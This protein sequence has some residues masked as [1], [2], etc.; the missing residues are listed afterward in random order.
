MNEKS[1][2]ITQSEQVRTVSGYG[3]GTG[4]LEHAMHSTLTAEMFASHVSLNTAEL[5][6][7]LVGIGDVAETQKIHCSHRSP[8][9]LSLQFQGNQHGEDATKPT[10]KRRC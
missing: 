1:M 6:Q 9:R 5:R 3:H 2:G 4:L 8:G 7:S 10:T